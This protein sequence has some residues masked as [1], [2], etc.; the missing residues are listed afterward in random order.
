MCVAPFGA[1][2]MAKTTP[3]LERQMH[4]K[5]RTPSA[6]TSCSLSPRRS[7]RSGPEN[8]TGN[9]CSYVTGP[10]T[11]VQEQDQALGRRQPEV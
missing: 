8:Q 10:L 2:K 1:T 6:F 7:R 4:I 9:W 3:Q 5:G 11:G